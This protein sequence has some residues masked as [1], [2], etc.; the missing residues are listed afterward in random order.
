M[1]ACPQGMRTHW[2]GAVMQ[3][4]H[5]LPG[6]PL[7]RF[8]AFLA[9]PAVSSSSSSERAA[10]GST[11]EPSPLPSS[12]SESRFSSDVLRSLASSHSSITVF[13]SR[14]RISAH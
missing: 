12:S 7:R 10:T 1:H 6:T 3:T 13:S 2:T 8:D 5:S 14:R 4:T 9:A 11:S